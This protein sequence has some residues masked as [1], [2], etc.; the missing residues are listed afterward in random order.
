MMSCIP[1]SFRMCASESVGFVVGVSSV[2]LSSLLSLLLL[3]LLFLLS[4]LFLFLCFCSCGCS[5]VDGEDVVFDD[6]SVVLPDVYEEDPVLSEDC[7]DV[8]SVFICVP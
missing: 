4:V 1:I 5:G 2:L 8:L 6:S 7:V 3:L